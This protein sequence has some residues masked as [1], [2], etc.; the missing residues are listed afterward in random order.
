M[1]I[2]LEPITD[3]S[4]YMNNFVFGARKICAMSLFSGLNIIPSKNLII[5]Q[6]VSITVKSWSYQMKKI[7]TSIWNIEVVSVAFIKKYFII[8]K[9]KAVQTY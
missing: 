6:I 7:E 4:S 2:Q 3:Y 8:Y 9:H 5:F 1:L